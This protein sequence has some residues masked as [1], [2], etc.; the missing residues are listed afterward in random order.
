MAER[1]GFEPSEPFNPLK[2]GIFDSLTSMSCGVDERADVRDSV[3]AHHGRSSAIVRK[4]NTET[5]VVVSQMSL[6]RSI[7]RG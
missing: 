7:K 6:K 2:L 1:G 4:R 5:R 3:V